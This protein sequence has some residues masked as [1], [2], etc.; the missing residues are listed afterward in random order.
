[1]V[2]FCACERIAFCDILAWARAHGATSVE[3]VE[4]G[5][6]AGRRCGLCRPFI[7]YALAT[8]EAEVPYPCPALPPQQSPD[9][10]PVGCGC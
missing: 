4:A 2:N 10:K 9:R 3:E 1:M 5:L 6:R 8:G 7:V